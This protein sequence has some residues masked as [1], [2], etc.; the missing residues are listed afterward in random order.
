MSND[1]DESV[2]LLVVDE[3]EYEHLDDEAWRKFVLTAVA[4][5]RNARSLALMGRAHRNMCHPRG[6]RKGRN[7]K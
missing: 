6:A 5:R 1:I 7:R 2:P 3:L 4:E